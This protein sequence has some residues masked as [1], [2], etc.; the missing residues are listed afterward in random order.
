[1]TSFSSHKNSHFVV[2]LHVK[3]RMI[4]TEKKQSM[5]FFLLVVFS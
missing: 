5:F 4:V 2:V 3:D 1:M